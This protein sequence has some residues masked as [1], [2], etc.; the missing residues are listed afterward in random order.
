[1]SV[2]LFVPFIA[3]CYSTFTGLI[4]KLVGVD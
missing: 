3:Y 1:V 4:F 2:A